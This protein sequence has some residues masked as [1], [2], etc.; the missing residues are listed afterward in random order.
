V[1]CARLAAQLPGGTREFSA[2]AEASPPGTAQ[3]ADITLARTDLAPSGTGVTV[4]TADGSQAP[5]PLHCA[6]PPFPGR[7]PASSR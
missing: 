1:T 4:T 2:T 6:F 5:P 3:Y 7:R